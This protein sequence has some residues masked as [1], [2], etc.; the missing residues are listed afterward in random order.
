M[1]KA[2]NR[3]LG[4]YK[5]EKVVTGRLAVGEDDI[6]KIWRACLEELY[7]VDTERVSY[8]Q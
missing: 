5:R 3:K 1:S 7:N 2:N 6:R 4:N 8:S